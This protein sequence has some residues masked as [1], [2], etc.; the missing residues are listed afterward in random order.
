MDQVIVRVGRGVSGLEFSAIDGLITP[1]DIDGYVALNF[2]SSGTTLP[3][4]AAT[5]P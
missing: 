1:E 2:T 4:S 5:P 3:L